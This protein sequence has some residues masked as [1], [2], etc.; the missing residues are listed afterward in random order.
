MPHRDPLIASTPPVRRVVVLVLDGL[1][2]DL[3]GRD[4]PAALRRASAAAL[5]LARPD[6]AAQITEQVLALAD[7]AREFAVPAPSRSLA[8]TQ[9][10]A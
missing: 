1:R 7:A 6:A 9:T 8:I 2:A 10:A 5:R 3:V 4:A